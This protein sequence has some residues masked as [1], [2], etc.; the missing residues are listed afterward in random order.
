MAL[1]LAIVRRIR[2]LIPDLEKVFGE[3]ENETMF[4]DA[5]I[6]DFYTE[7]FENVKCAA[8]LAKITIGSSEALILK[9]IKNYETTTDGAKA[10]KEW[11]AAGTKLYEFGLDQIAAADE[12]IFEVVYPD[13]DES[14]H[15]EGLSHG[16]YRLGG[17]L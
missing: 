10:M 4:S 13:W 7:G 12:G 8:G 5:D 2:V 11:V 14:R 3:G 16:S 15:P 6:E 9:V 17:W 1:D